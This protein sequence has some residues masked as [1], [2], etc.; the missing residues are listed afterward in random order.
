[1]CRVSIS[2][3]APRAESGHKAGV[4]VVFGTKGM[5][6]VPPDMAWLSQW[7]PSVPFTA[8]DI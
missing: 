3:P 5:S 8:R 6:P 1:M 2:G 7:A 4:W